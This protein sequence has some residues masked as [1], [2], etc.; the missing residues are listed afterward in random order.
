ME[1]F[2]VDHAVANV[3]G[4]PLQ[5]DQFIYA[6][7]R[8]TP[9]EGEL[10]RFQLM[11][12]KVNLP[13]QGKRFHVFQIGQINPNLL[14]F[15]TNRPDWVNE[16][17]LNIAD[18][19]EANKIA[20]VLYTK[21]GTI[22]PRFQSYLL[23]SNER[24]LV[25]AVQENSSIKIDYKIDQIY[26]KVYSNAW[27]GSAEANASDYFMRCKGKIASSISDVMQTQAEITQLRTLPGYVNCYINGFLVEDIS[28]LTAFTNDTIEY[29]YDSSVKRIVSFVANSLNSFSS[30]LD[31][32]AKFLL[33]YA[34]TGENTI[35]YQDDIDVYI[36]APLPFNRYKG[37][38]YHHNTPESIRMVTHR[39]YSLNIDYFQYIANKLAE[40]ISSTPL[41]ILTFKIQLMIRKSG[42]N[43]P[44]IFDNSRIFE[45]YKLPD[46]KILQSMLGINS[47]LSIWRADQLEK[48]AYTSIMRA[49][50]VESITMQMV[51]D[52]YGYNSISKLV[53]DS[54][55]KT[56][57]SSGR[58]VATIPEAM[59][60]SCT[61]YEY[62]VNGY[63][64]GYYPFS[65][66]V[67]YEAISSDTRL[68][69]VISGKGTDTPSVV[70]GTDNLPLPVYD[71]YRVYMSYL[72][73]GVSNNVWED[74]T[75]S[76]HYT[77]INNTLVWNNQIAGQYLMVKTDASF[78]AYSLEIPCVEGN[79]FFTLVENEN[80]G[81]GVQ[82][83][84]VPVPGGEFDLYLNS[85]SL[86]K[87]LDYVVDFP[88]VYI[89]NK[90]YLVQPG[91]TALQKITVR[92]T[93]FCTK[94]LQFEH[95]DD[96]GFIQYGYL[97]NNNRY[98]LRDDKVL[99][100]TVD[101]KTLHRDGL[102]F[103][104]DHSGVSLLDPENGLPY[105]IKDIIVPLKQLVNDNTYTLREKSIT[106]DKAVSDYM[107]LMDP[108][109]DRGTVDPIVQKYVVVSPFVCRIIAALGFTEIT[110]EQIAGVKN[111]ND[112]LAI[113]KPYEYT[114]AF[115][116]INTTLEYDYRFV[117]VHPHHNDTVMNMP[118]SQYK[119]LT[120]VVS[121][122]CHG[123]VQ[124]SPFFTVS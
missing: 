42:T 13:V 109:P 31:N 32:V 34:G 69:E 108:Q 78:L 29:V 121:L 98:D 51:Q 73:Q 107:T 76:S 112:V 39:D 80:R 120:K 123:V 46:D 104:E 88:K 74:I 72:V 23:F 75:G 70:F 110:P 65:G 68:I 26:F 96:Y 124:L 77:V 52:A 113:C 41:D 12:R 24:N 82:P 25:L 45:M 117:D 36:L 53:G 103:S 61:V 44:L 43:K 58:Q 111:D 102:V 62:D 40:D 20:V 50:D 100:I 8:I 5:D 9:P 91:E 48:N 54:P 115:D 30:I 94:D 16:S 17:W 81:N 38:Y 116:P 105:Q 57:L 10:N 60:E 118:L 101:G 86:I 85:K 66:D 33:H 1:Q 27:F 4:N 18:A 71:N 35:D 19:I 3:W 22:I 28:P 99:R 119:F 15:I 64:L 67:S 92:M 7:A 79:L 122:Y 56:T 37:Y 55:I 87:G 47:T 84:I 21:D 2:L 114:L 6:A 95:I 14:G 63:L 11:N 83:F 106:I 59:I 90:K 49:P 93:G 97:S 89:V